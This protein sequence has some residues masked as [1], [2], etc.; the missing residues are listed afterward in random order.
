M[1]TSTINLVG[2]IFSN[3]GHFSIGPGFN[4]TFPLTI[5]DNAIIKAVTSSKVT[6]YFQVITRT[7]FTVYIISTFFMQIFVICTLTTH[8]PWAETANGRSTLLD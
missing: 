4:S 2:I 3:F 5:N 8:D 7:L 6:H 1:T